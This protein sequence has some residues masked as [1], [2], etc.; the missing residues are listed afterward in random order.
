MARLYVFAP[1]G[2]AH[3]L[4]GRI[5]WNEGVGEFT[6]A[7]SWLAD[8]ASY[9]LD[10][11][12][13]PL[14]TGAF[15]T[16]LN[17]GVHGVLA[18]AGPD[19]WGRKLLELHRGRVPETPLELLRVANGAGTGG[20]LFSQH[21]DRPDPTRALATM[22]S[23]PELE[24]AARQISDGNVVSPV[25]VELIFASGSPLGGAR[26]KANVLH[27]GVQWIAKFSRSDDV[28]DVPRVEW[29]CLATARAAGVE[30]PD[31]ALVAVNGRSVLLVKRFDR[32][33]GRGVH[34][35]SFHALLS[36]ERL[37][38]ADITAPTGVC[39]YGG[40]AAMCR[41][42]GVADVGSILFRRM[43]V[44][45]AIG[46]TDD[47]LRNH[48]LL[49]LDGHWRMA[50]AFDLTATGGELQAI[51]VGTGGRAATLDNALSDL[52]RFDL[53]KQDAWAI[54]AEVRDAMIGMR[55]RLIEAELPAGQLSLVLARMRQ[56]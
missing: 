37:T 44:N 35:L 43:I 53:G 24:D 4:A 27:E 41:Q 31:H 28:V 10:P 33:V 48:G 14:S 34:Y 45:L 51:G 19:A 40:L 5:D 13:L 32:P 7:P 56:V 15:I 9:S 17:E 29:A 2:E 3:R 1:L 11:R 21:R 39:T 22:S 55:E 12:N 6:Y 30:V 18:D 52:S 25:D 46:N 8:A 16:T 47:H 49:C 54:Q 36:M 38:R 23:L 50:P 20:L 42:I 26:P